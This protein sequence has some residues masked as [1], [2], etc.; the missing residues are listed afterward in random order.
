MTGGVAGVF[1][2][3]D[4]VLF[5]A[6]LVRLTSSGFGFSA[7]GDSVE[8]GRAGPGGRLIASFGAKLF[9]TLSPTEMYS[10]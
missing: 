8:A 5:F 10:T 1:V 3:D 6:T 7:T 9:L 4:E 2:E